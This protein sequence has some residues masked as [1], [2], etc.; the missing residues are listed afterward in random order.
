[1][2]ILNIDNPSPKQQV[3]LDMEEIRAEV[4]NVNFE[5]QHYNSD[6][7]GARGEEHAKCM[8]MFMLHLS[9]CHSVLIES[10]EEAMEDE[11]C[12]DAEPTFSA[13]SPDEQALV[14]AAKYF[15]WK[16]FERRQG[17]VDILLD[18][19]IQTYWILAVFEFTS[20]RK[21][22]TVIVQ[23]A[24]GEIT[25]L[26]K[27]AENVIY[28]RVSKSTTSTVLER[29]TA[30]LESF[31]RDGLRTLVIASKAITQE[32]WTSFSS[33]YEAALTN[34]GEVEK[35]AKGEDNRIDELQNEMED[36]LSLLGI[37]GIEDRLQDGVPETMEKLAIPG[38]DVWV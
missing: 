11:E 22:M 14:S 25:V 3:V 23:D 21:R 32:K 27:G 28:E 20:A 34:L 16:F 8:K 30:V 33:N 9:L 29:N 15:G 37:T 7:A 6:I 19:E 2:F 31:A 1:M 35:K 13:S 10:C 18:G 24:A 38:I 36:G 4:E 26:V 12:I 5:D 17:Q